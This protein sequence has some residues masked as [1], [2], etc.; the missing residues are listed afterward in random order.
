MNDIVMKSTAVPCGHV[1]CS[2]PT[3][4]SSQ[5]EGLNGVRILSM[6]STKQRATGSY[7][8]SLFRKYFNFKSNKAR[9]LTFFFNLRR[10]T[11]RNEDTILSHATG[12]PEP[13]YP[14]EDVYYFISYLFIM[15][16]PNSV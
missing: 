3:D 9:V 7:T 6:G 14:T 10:F 11:S 13:D 12:L 16:L 5:W 1:L 15:H 8:K 4:G 2:L